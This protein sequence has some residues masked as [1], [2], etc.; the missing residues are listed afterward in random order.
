VSYPDVVEQE[1]QATEGV[2]W[3]SRARGLPSGY[4]ARAGE[5]RTPTISTVMTVTALG[6]SRSLPAPAP[7]SYAGRPALAPETPI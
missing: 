4:R 6:E 2:N 5:A 1:V 3:Q 7:C